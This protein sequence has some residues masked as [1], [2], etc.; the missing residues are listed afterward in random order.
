MGTM[1]D[2]F[3]YVLSQNVERAIQVLL[4]EKHLYQSVEVDMTFVPK[5]ATDFV[6]KKMSSISVAVA[7]PGP[8]QTVE[9]VTKHWMS[10]AN[11]HWTPHFRSSSGSKTQAFQIT[12]PTCGISFAMP[13]I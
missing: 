11:S 6:T 12:G 8:P 2:D 7:S 3:N 9:S 4:C 1:H 5:L 13:T 10:I